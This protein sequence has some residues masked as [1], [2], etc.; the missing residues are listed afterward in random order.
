MEK[1]RGKRAFQQHVFYWIMKRSP[2]PFY[3]VCALLSLCHSLNLC[4]FFSDI[5]PSFLT[6]YTSVCVSL[7]GSESLAILMLCAPVI[8]ISRRVCLILSLPQSCVGVC[9]SWFC[10]IGGEGTI[11]GR[12]KADSERGGGERDRE[13]LYDT[14]NVI[15]HISVSA[16]VCWSRVGIKTERGEIGGWHRRLERR[17]NSQN[18]HTF[19]Y[20]SLLHHITALIAFLD[21]LHGSSAYEQYESFAVS[22]TV[23]ATFLSGRVD[24]QSFK[25]PVLMITTPVLYLNWRAPW[26]L[27]FQMNRP[28]QVKPADSESRGGKRH[29]SPPSNTAPV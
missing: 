11:D 20:M 8:Q 10:V 27:S 6:L 18:I 4:L 17:P 3:V 12:I 2:N 7:S 22:K 9:F 14:V 1:K 29:L 25:Y 13:R 5:I 16:V 23:V 26:P 24:R 15:S 21:G 19:T 28:I